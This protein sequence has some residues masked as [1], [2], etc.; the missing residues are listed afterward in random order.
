MTRMS[1]AALPH[2]SL[3]LAKDCPTTNTNQKAQLFNTDHTGCN[4]DKLAV[5]RKTEKHVRHPL[6]AKCSPRQNPPVRHNAEKKRMGSEEGAQNE[7][8]CGAKPKKGVLTSFIT[9]PLRRFG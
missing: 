1:V 4:S 5:T 3:L 2:R 7:Q 6:V 8:L 9:G